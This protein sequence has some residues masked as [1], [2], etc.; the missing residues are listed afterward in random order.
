MKPIKIKEIWKSCNQLKVGIT[1]CIFSVYT[2]YL[3]RQHVQKRGGGADKDWWHN[4]AAALQLP[5]G[6]LG[7]PYHATHGSLKRNAS[8]SSS[9]RLH[10]YFNTMTV[11]WCDNV[12][13]YKSERA[14]PSCFMKWRSSSP[15][16]PNISATVQTIIINICRCYLSSKVQIHI[17]N[18]FL[19]WN[20]DVHEFMLE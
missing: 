8:K 7:G 15:L 5:W 14:Q 1:H 17:Y 19:A 6:G 4:D 3:Q 2:L 12:H 18:Y 9:Q 20:A 11:Q 16:P 13:G 10:L